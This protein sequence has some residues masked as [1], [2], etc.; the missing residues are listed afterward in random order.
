M[1]VRERRPDIYEF[2]SGCYAKV[3]PTFLRGH[4]LGGVAM[5]YSSGRR[6]LTSFVPR[7]QFSAK[8]EK[9]AIDGPCECT[10]QRTIGC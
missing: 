6:R 5:R 8:H 3:L 2:M 1:D 7:E 4:P 10:H 9:R